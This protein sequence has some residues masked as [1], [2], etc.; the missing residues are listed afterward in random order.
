MDGPPNAIPG[1]YP[2]NDSLMCIGSVCGAFQEAGANM[3]VYTG[4]KSFRKASL[5]GKSGFTSIPFD[6]AGPGDLIQAA[7]VSLRDYRDESKGYE[8]RPHHA[9]IINKIADDGTV[10]AYNAKGGSIEQF[11]LSDDFLHGEDPMTYRYTGKVPSIEKEI[12]N[13]EGD[14]EALKFLL[15]NNSDQGFIDRMP[16]KPIE[17]NFPTETIMQ[18]SQIPVYTQPS[19]FWNKNFKTKNNNAK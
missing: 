16:L 8:Y 14:A 13:F 7:E 3:P 10:S 2:M 15:K 12:S 4:N 6:Q 5:A 1:S 19:N 18:P 11:G 9:G 17:H